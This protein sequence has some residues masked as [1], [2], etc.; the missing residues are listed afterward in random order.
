MKKIV[1]VYLVLQNIM[2]VLFMSSIKLD[3]K[4]IQDVT[5]KKCRERDNN[6]LGQTV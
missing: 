4:N 6:I 5:L 1:Q 2:F 3:S